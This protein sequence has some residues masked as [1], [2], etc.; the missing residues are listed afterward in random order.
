MHW[1]G[2]AM[3]VHVSPILNPTLTSFPIPSLRI[4]KKYIC[5]FI[6]LAESGLRCGIFVVV[7]RLL[8]SCGTVLVIVAQG[9]S[10]PTACG[11]SLFPD[12]ELNL[13]TWIGRQIVN[14]WTIREVP[15]T[16]IHYSVSSVLLLR[17]SFNFFVY[18]TIYVNS[19][20]SI[21]LF[22]IFSISVLRLSIFSFV[23]NM[24]I[25]PCGIR[26]IILAFISLSDISNLCVFLVLLFIDYLF[27]IML[28][29]SFLFWLMFIC[30]QTIS[31]TPSLKPQHFGLCIFLEWL[32]SFE[33]M[34][35]A[36]IKKNLIGFGN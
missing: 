33:V 7:C 1:H 28:S 31:F 32:F 2:S 27:S 15:S 4:F 34:E 24:F 6:C 11:I 23:S 16:P 25:I 20:I 29:F 14:H 9:L 17:P 8:S 19:K 10:C 21:W 13:C 22:F 3:C 36:W 30:K 12:Q 5:S 26:F 18:V 35:I